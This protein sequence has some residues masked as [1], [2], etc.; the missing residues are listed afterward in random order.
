MR[1]LNVLCI[2]SIYISFTVLHLGFATEVAI[3]FG[4]ATEVA[5]SFGFATSVANLH[6][7]KKISAALSYMEK[8]ADIFYTINGIV[9]GFK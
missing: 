7:H 3:S 6:F 4:F 2:K 5:T 9:R 8:A 1:T